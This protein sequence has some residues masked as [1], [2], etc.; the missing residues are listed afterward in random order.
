MAWDRER[1]EEWKGEM[2]KM[3]RRG[4]GI[5]EG[6]KGDRRR[7]KEIGGEEERIGDERKGD[8]GR[9]GKEI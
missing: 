1:E 6:R 5:R 8:R 2:K 4:K 7:G 9:R 3:G